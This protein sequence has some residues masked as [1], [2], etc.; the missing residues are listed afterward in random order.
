MLV[1]KLAVEKG[2]REVPPELEDFMPAPQTGK[3][4]TQQRNS[5]ACL[6]LYGSCGRGGIV[7]Q[8][9]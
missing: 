8:P 2:V 9:I 6:E 5:A 7:S 3:T 4:G 1:A